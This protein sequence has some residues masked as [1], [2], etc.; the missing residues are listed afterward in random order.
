[1]AATAHTIVT[2]NVSRHGLQFRS[3]VP[4]C[5]GEYFRF[6]LYL[7]ETGNEIE[8]VAQAIEVTKEE[9]GFCVGSKIIEISSAH[10]KE[11]QEYVDHWNAEE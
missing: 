5:D 9:D 8:G 4:I 6:S 11:L 2:T 1:M 10:G 3:R 7:R